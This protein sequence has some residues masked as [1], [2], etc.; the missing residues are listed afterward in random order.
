[1]Q[2]GPADGVRERMLRVVM[3]ISNVREFVHYQNAP[4][5]RLI[6]RTGQV[7]PYIAKAK[8]NAAGAR[9]RR[10]G[11]VFHPSYGRLRVFAGGP[12]LLPT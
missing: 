10:I 11:R 2:R 3:L 9:V 4:H 6:T 7:G 8:E 1:M 5:K 12:D